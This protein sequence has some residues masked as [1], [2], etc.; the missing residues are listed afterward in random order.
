M[1]KI[2]LVILSL[3]ISV[4]SFAKH[5]HKK[6][7]PASNIES[8]SMRRTA[9]YGHCPVYTIEIDKN[10]TA[11][12]TATLFNADTGTFTKN[13]GSKKV[14]DI[15]NQFN[16]YRVDTCQNAYKP[17]ATDLPGV[18]F[19]IHYTNNTKTIM[20]VNYGPA[21]LKQLIEVMDSIVGKK[22]DNT[23]QKITPPH[24]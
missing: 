5:K 11:T 18:M 22:T 19:T 13:I 6:S 14:M 1:R 15:F 17:R 23:W 7:Q 4:S 20:N 24:N 10:G 12:Y 9:C 21:F 8:V 16:T 2:A 3:I